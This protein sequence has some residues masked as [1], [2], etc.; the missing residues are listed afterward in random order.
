MLFGAT[1]DLAKRKLLPGLFRPATAGLMPE[2]YHVI[3][4][5]RRST[6]D[7]QFRELARQAVAEFGTTNR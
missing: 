2:R 5:S 6:T 7:E 3:G 1:G 4:S